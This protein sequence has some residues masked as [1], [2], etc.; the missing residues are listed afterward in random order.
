MMTG[1]GSGAALADM[2]LGTAGMFGA[3]TADAAMLSGLGVTPGMSSGGIGWGKGLE[4]LQKVQKLQQLAGGG[5]ERRREPP[6]WQ[7]RPPVDM[8]TDAM[9]Y[10]EE[11]YKLRR[12]S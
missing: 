8:N 6:P 1:L 2:G 10:I 7:G 12:Y 5:E 3:G 9:K 4:A 11:I